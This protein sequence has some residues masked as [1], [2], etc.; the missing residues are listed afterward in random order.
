MYYVILVK[1]R[2]ALVVKKFIRNLVVC[3]VFVIFIDVLVGKGLVFAETAKTQSPISQNY[4]AQK[5]VQAS[6]AVN[7]DS[8]TQ[9]PEKDNVSLQKIW[10]IKLNKAVDPSSV[11]NDSIKVIEK[12]S[13]S[14]V[15]VALH[16]QSS[17]PTEVDIIAPAGGYTPGTEYSIIVSKSLKSKDAGSLKS[18]VVMDFKTQYLPT[19]ATDVNVNVTEFDDFTLPS[20]VQATMPD[21]STQDWDV[22]WGGTVPDTSIAGTFTYSGKLEG[23]DV[24]V[25]VNL[26]V[27]PFQVSTVSNGTRTQSSIQVAAV[28]YVMASRANRDSIEDAAAKLNY[29]SE[30]NTCV[31]FASEMYRRVGFNIPISTCNTKGLT[32]FLASSGWK[33]DTNKDDLIT[34]DQCFT[35][36]D[37][38]GY[39]THTY[40]FI[41]WVDPSDHTWAYIVDNQRSLYND[42]LHKR[43]IMTVDVADFDAFQFFMYKP[44]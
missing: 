3:T 24:S 43:E 1:G 25:N 5:N 32:T 39:P 13:G 10:A 22:D 2:E 40:L 42:G 15:K 19:S 44:N 35:K 33:K 20:K 23:T 8:P 16:V 6:A 27:A 41:K 11:T 31:Y 30:S 37:G 21:G 9:L 4:A 29:N 14:T 7:G 26:T 28:N 34:G 38:T 17:D 12:A 36:N 18:D